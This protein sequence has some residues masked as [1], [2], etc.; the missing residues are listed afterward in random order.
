MYVYLVPTKPSILCRS[1]NSIWNSW[2]ILFLLSNLKKYIS[3]I[4]VYV[5]CWEKVNT[6]NVL[7]MFANHFHMA[8]VSY[9]AILIHWPYVFNEN[10]EAVFRE[11]I[12]DLAFWRSLHEVTNKRVHTVS[13]LSQENQF[14]TA[15]FN[16]P[17]WIPPLGELFICTNILPGRE[18]AKI[19]SWRYTA[20]RRH[21]QYQGML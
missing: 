21:G 18:S 4:F 7:K 6:I 17:L 11:E 14:L 9:I 15:S 2:V 19:Y 1:Y 13:C 3:Y 5:L 16:F 20:S 12:E 8:Y 10:P